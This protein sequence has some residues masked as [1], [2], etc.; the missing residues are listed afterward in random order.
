M[1]TSVPCNQNMAN[2]FPISNQPIFL[3][4]LL[5]VVFFKGNVIL[6][7]IVPDKGKVCKSN[8]LH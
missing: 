1:C 8:L 7:G 5:M 4:V 6:N 2:D 3:N